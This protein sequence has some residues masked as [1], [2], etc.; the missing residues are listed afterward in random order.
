MDHLKAS[1]EELPDEI[2]NPTPPPP[3]DQLY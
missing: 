2:F 3:D 1:G